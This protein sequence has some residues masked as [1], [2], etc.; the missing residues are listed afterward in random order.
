MKNASK[1]V[2]AARAGR[3]LGAALLS[4]GLLLAA[5][6]EPP[7]P[8]AAAKGGPVVVEK[9]DGILALKRERRVEIKGLRG[10]IGLRLG[11]DGEVRYAARSLAN[12]EEERAVAVSIE[13]TTVHIGP[14]AGA[15]PAETLRI[16]VTV[17]ALFDS[18][19]EADG[20]EVELSGLHGRVELRGKN[21]QLAVRTLDAELEVELQGGKVQI[22]G[23]SGGLALSGRGL[24][25]RAE[26]VGGTVQLTLSAKSRAILNQVRGGLEG[27]I[28]DTELKASGVSGVV[29]LDTSGG[30]V[31]LERCTG[32][33]DL[34]LTEAKL[35]LQSTGGPFQIET[36]AE[37]RF[38]THDGPL[39]ARVRD[40][41]IHGAQA[42]GGAVDIEAEGAQ[43]QLENFDSPVSVRGQQ[44]DVHLTGM[45]GDV[46]VQTSL[47]KVV[48]EDA[49]GS[50]AIE[51]EF[52][53]VAVTSAQKLVRVTSRDGD[54]RLDELSGP[55]E[56]QAE[57]AE[58]VVNWISLAGHEPS[59]IENTRGDVRVG[60]PPDVRCQIDAQAPHGRVETEFEDLR[61]SEDGH[62]ATGLLR[63]G[64]GAAPQV[65]QSLIR[66]R[67]SGDLYLYGTNSQAAEQEP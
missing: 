16:E 31:E 63:G 9:A 41:A 17:P 37:L 5:E 33:G 57:G 2:R 42:K 24:D 26:N 29:G 52:G 59:A 6:A 3:A 66:I 49:A 13:D 28:E 50:V 39:T 51:N 8:R 55:T 40:A 58:V 25:L 45:K 35:Q 56:V 22:A 53:D 27:E 4:C 46:S 19:V 11:R 14:R 36:D 20:S 60:V 15:P 21:T 54:V 7:P 10:K 48:V 18:K 67:A 43:V 34:T 44:L 32:G 30:A 62:G 38:Q 47:S 23:L 64:Q 61:L 1:K 65:K 12:S